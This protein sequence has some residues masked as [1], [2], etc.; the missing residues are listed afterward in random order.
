MAN[1]Q[2]QEVVWSFAA[3]RGRLE[4]AAEPTLNDEVRQFLGFLATV[5]TPLIEGSTVDFI[6][7]DPRARAIALTG[8]FN[9]WGRTGVRL[10]MAR[11]RQTGIFHRTLELSEPARLEYKLIVDGRVILN[12][13]CPKTVDNGSV[14]GSSKMRL[15]RRPILQC[16]SGSTRTGS[17]VLR[18]RACVTLRKTGSFNWMRQMRGGRRRQ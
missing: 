4:R 11:V 15:T 12:P 2:R 14:V 16:S 8:E 10:P 1:T 18:S 6:C 13:R 5:G 9:D 3:W 7:Y 17:N